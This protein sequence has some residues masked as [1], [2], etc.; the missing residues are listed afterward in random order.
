M[1]T[2]FI[3]VLLLINFVDCE[4]PR[5]IGLKEGNEVK[6][7]DW[8]YMH[9]FEKKGGIYTDSQMKEKGKLKFFE[10][11]YIIYGDN[12]KDT[13][14]YNTYLQ[15]DKTEFKSIVYNDQ[16][17]V[18]ENNEEEIRGEQL[19]AHA[20]GFFIWNAEGGIH[21]MHSFPGYP[22]LDAN[23]HL[24]ENKFFKDPKTEK[25]EGQHM[26]CTELNS[27]NLNIITKYLVY[28]NPFIISINNN[29]IKLKTSQINTESVRPEILVNSK[30]STMG[31]SEKNIEKLININEFSKMDEFLDENI[32]ICQE[33]IPMLEIG[34]VPEQN[35]ID[36]S[37]VVHVFEYQLGSYYVKKNFLSKKDDSIYYYIAT[38]S[39]PDHWY[40]HTHIVGKKLEP[41]LDGQRT[42]YS[43]DIM[44][45]YSSSDTL[46]KST[47]EHAKLFFSSSTFC[48]GD[49]NWSISKVYTDGST[50]KN[51]KFVT[52]VEYP[53]NL[54][55]ML[56]D[57]FLKGL[58]Y[59]IELYSTTGN[60]PFNPRIITKSSSVKIPLKVEL[61]QDSNNYFLEPFSISF[62]HSGDSVLICKE[63]DCDLQSSYKTLYY[64]NVKVE[65]EIH[66]ESLNHGNPKNTIA[67]TIDAISILKN[68][69]VARKCIS[70]LKNEYNIT[71]RIELFLI[72]N[73]KLKPNDDCTINQKYLKFNPEC[74]D[75]LIHCLIPKYKP[76]KISTINEIVKRY[77][78]KYHLFKSCIENKR[79]KE[80]IANESEE[81]SKNKKIK[82]EEDFNSSHNSWAS[83]NSNDNNI[84][85]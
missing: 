42:I 19:T 29:V 37:R 5:C 64:S 28:T 76:D 45:F 48:V 20:K 32:K 70:D 73:F 9:K 57:D 31:L 81:H 46:Y 65:G 27:Q 75:Q 51:V 53:I 80:E 67:T 85:N 40:S 47:Q 83:R 41:L 56:N 58:S 16:H 14:L 21:V 33:E 1:F 24:S 36:S 11:S 13:P 84:N 55:E 50:K 54:K 39:Q 23:N 34:A 25:D 52:S 79:K 2:L 18:F 44:V 62:F 15:K 74:H 8:W 43:T 38:N 71:E 12:E 7:V 10:S 61:K 26:L 3:F 72:E 6:H 66:I 22:I 78:S 17:L 68:I 63:L 35:S 30:C 69:Q 82:N 60:I 4:R 59:E 77:S 49:L